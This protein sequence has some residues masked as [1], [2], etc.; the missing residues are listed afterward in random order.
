VSPVPHALAHL[1]AEHFCPL[2]QAVPQLSQLWNVSFTHEA[3]QMM[4]RCRHWWLVQ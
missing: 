4:Q 2:A 3:P 1:L